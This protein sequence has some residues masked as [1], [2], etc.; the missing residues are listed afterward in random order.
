LLTVLP[1]ISKEEKKTMWIDSLN[2]SNISAGKDVSVGLHCKNLNVV[3]QLQIY[4]KSWLT[5]N[6]SR[7][8]QKLLSRET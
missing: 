1:L 8:D 7:N 2:K 6:I 3:S 5:L 4:K